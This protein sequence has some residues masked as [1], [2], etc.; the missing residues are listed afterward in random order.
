MVEVPRGSTTAWFLL[1]IFPLIFCLAAPLLEGLPAPRPGLRRRAAGRRF[2][3]NVHNG[4]YV[5]RDPTPL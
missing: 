4:R 3:A 1:M 2:D 5:N